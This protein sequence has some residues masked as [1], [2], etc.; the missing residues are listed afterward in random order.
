MSEIMDQLVEE[1]KIEP[2]VLMLQDRIPE[3]VACRYLL[4]PIER[5]EEMLAKAKDKISKQKE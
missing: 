4:I 2:L 3:D 1:S 5:Q